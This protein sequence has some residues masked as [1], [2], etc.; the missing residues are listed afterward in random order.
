MNYIVK[1]TQI[2]SEAYNNWDVYYNPHP[3]IELGIC[4]VAQLTLFF[5][6][7]FNDLSILEV[8]DSIIPLWDTC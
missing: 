6:S 2:R 7:F 8:F 3:V 5:F 4:Q 1:W